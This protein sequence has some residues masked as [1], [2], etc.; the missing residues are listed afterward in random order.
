M[1]EVFVSDGI[2]QNENVGSLDSDSKAKF[3]AGRNHVGKGDIATE[4]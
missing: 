3:V 1:R 4:A 2:S